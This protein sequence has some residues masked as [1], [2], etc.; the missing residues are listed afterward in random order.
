MA[1]ELFDRIPIR[2]VVSWNAMI[3]G[4][5]QIGQFD[6]AL[7]LFQEMR[8]AKATPDVSTLLSVLSVC[9]HLGALEIG[10]LV[11][12]WIENHGHDSNLRIVNAL[13]DMYAK[14]GDLN[15]AWTLFE[16]LQEKD[17]VSWNVMIGGYTHMSSYKKAL[18]VFRTNAA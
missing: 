15:M 4:Y 16:S 8:K 10:N 2:D 7:S 6:E 18:E 3:S 1:R 5:A 13:I 12:S 9:A 11:R 14:C 17:I